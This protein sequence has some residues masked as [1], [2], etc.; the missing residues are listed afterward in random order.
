VSGG[1]QLNA[2]HSLQKHSG[3]TENSGADSTDGKYRSS[4]MESRTEIIQWGS[5]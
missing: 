5:L 4:R 1:E 2:S 3:A